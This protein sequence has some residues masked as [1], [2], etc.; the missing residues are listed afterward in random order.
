MEGIWVSWLDRVVLRGAD[1]GER[2]RENERSEGGRA[3]EGG[4]RECNVTKSREGE[5]RREKGEGKRR[6]GEGRIKRSWYDGCVRLTYDGNGN[7]I[8]VK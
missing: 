6:R 8:E 2:K 3:G 7:E 1:S 5:G 4:G